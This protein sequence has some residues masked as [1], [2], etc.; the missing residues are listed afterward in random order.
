MKKLL[1]YL[2]GLLFLSTYITAQPAYKIAL[3]GAAE[4]SATFTALPNEHS[5]SFTFIVPQ[6]QFHQVISP[7]GESFLALDGPLL[8]KDFG[9]G[10]PALPTI[11]QMVEIPAGS[12]VQIVVHSF[13]EQ[14][15]AL[16]EHGLDWPIAPAQVS[17]PKSRALP[18]SLL[19]QINKD[20]YTQNQFYKPEFAHFTKLGHL[21]NQEVG[22][23]RINPFEYNPVT[24][25]L[26]IKNNI[27]LSLRIVSRKKSQGKPSTSKPERL[28]AIDLP[29]FTPREKSAQAEKQKQE[30]AS[31][32]YV[33]LADPMFKEVLTPLIKWKTEKGFIVEDYYTDDPRIGTEKETI[34]SFLNRLYHYPEDEIKPTY[35]LLVGDVDQ[36]P[37]YW[38]NEESHATDLYYFDYTNDQLPDVYYGRFSAETEEQANAQIQKTLQLEKLTL[39]DINFLEKSLLI[40]GVDATY[41]PTYGNGAVYYASNE[42]FIPENGFDSYNYFYNKNGQQLNSDDPEASSQIISRINEGIGFGN[43]TAHCNYNGWSNPML[44][45]NHVRNLNNKN[46]YPVLVGNCCLSAKYDHDDSFGEWLVQSTD[47]GA[48][49]YIGGSNYTYW[50]EDYW[51]AIGLTNQIT[52]TPTYENSGMGVFDGLFQSMNQNR[53]QWFNTLGQ[54]VR[55]GNLQVESSN[56]KRKQYYWEIYQLLGDPA[57]APYLGIPQEMAVHH[58]VL[59]Q[60]GETSLTVKTEPNALVALSYQG[61]LIAA[62]YT[63]QQGEVVFNTENLP[64][65]H[66]YKIV[67][68]KPNKIP[69]TGEVTLVREEPYITIEELIWT[70]PSGKQ[71]ENLEYNTT[72]SL[73][74]QLKNN[75]PTREASVVA[76]SLG[77]STQSLEHTGQ[78][79]LS[80]RI[81]PLEEQ[82]I[83][84][85]IQVADSVPDMQ[86]T[87]LHFTMISEDTDGSKYEIEE[88]HDVQVHAPNIQLLN[89]A[90][91]NDQQMGDGDNIAEAGEEI[92][93]QLTI[94]NTGHSSLE[95]LRFNLLPTTGTQHSQIRTSELSYSSL[96]SGASINLSFKLRIDNR[97][98]PYD[99]VDTLLLRFSGGSNLQYQFQRPIELV[100]NQVPEIT[101]NQEGIHNVD[102]M[103]FYD[104]GGSANNYASDEV[105]EIEF[106]PKNPENILIA[107]FMSYH[108]ETS[109]S[110]C[111]DY[112]EASD[113]QGTLMLPTCGEELPPMIRSRNPGTPLRF[114]FNSDQSIQKE[115]WKALIEEKSPITLVCYV[116]N[117]Q[118]QPLEEVKIEVS[119]REPLY[120]NKDGQAKIARCFNGELLEL[121]FDTEGYK[122]Q[123]QEVT[124]SQNPIITVHLA[125]VYNAVLRITDGKQ[126]I[127]GAHVAVNNKQ[128]KQSNK[129]GVV[130][131][132]DLKENEEVQYNITADGYITKSGSL[133]LK[134]SNIH[135]DILLSPYKY[136][137]Q[138]NVTNNNTPLQDAKLVVE[139]TS[140]Y[141]NEDGNAF[142]FLGNGW[143]PYYLYIQETNILS[144]SLFIQYGDTVKQL[145]LNTTAI[146][147]TDNSLS[148]FPNPANEYVRIQSA[149]FLQGTIVIRSI[150]GEVVRRKEIKGYAAE[151]RV[152]DLPEGI[153]LLSLKT[154]KLRHTQRLIIRK[155]T[156]G[157]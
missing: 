114:R 34:H 8:K 71:V 91:V 35:V 4:K 27:H 140:K 66:P 83:T 22:L 70:D 130:I 74:A 126:P 131:I 48:V 139:N 28:F 105:Y 67:V 26:L 119:G 52:T 154:D 3:T 33:I 113:N 138:F 59:L 31:I 152:E 41:A 50:D 111:Y 44:V 51:W 106:S 99:H 86:R 149:N 112:L 81:P 145:N 141:T 116:Y 69:Y 98:I 68:T 157:N 107:N 29:S 9:N 60:E 102:A 104:S 151:I 61:D 2:V 88:T 147:H 18:D 30:E 65:L 6:L 117:E 85:T 63:P 148:I 127:E 153:Y 115:G 133:K 11:N 10:Q 97:E 155:Q 58:P 136:T 87:Q 64:G 84:Y 42:Y 135:K 96:A 36:I 143:H 20:L 25:E 142:F 129:E 1:T 150:T 53:N 76:T 17:Q 43:Y 80:T 137:V 103:W 77:F 108:T 122:T 38:N 120:T 92:S 79:R 128:D 100:L 90:R 118:N 156:T 23:L 93:L 89:E 5:L 125:K 55:A 134:S 40:A 73:A 47:K 24:G 21:R 16:G 146:D 95:Q 121:T 49:A 37:A 56:S 46:K 110:G 123:T 72:Y 82:T 144:D 124:I 132:T 54:L 94:K 101:I 12:D 78:A 15:I 32:K 14:L 109:L 45:N 13:E 57:F 39:P 62:Y 75:S 19:W 7:K